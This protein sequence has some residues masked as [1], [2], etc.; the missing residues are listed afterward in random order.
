[1]DGKESRSLH[2]FPSC[3][4][5]FGMTKQQNSAKQLSFNKKIILLKKIHTKKG[6]GLLYN[7]EEV[8]LILTVWKYTYICFAHLSSVWSI[9]VVNEIQELNKFTGL[10]CCRMPLNRAKNVE[11]RSFLRDKT[12]LCDQITS[13]ILLTII[14]CQLWN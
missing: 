4:R 6:Y 9:K 3:Y 8:V 5:T 11:H 10:S 13:T 14:C 12:C 1:M 2:W 7:P